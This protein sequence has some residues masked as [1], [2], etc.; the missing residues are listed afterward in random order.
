MKFGRRTQCNV[1]TQ[2]WYF[3]NAMQ[4]SQTSKNPVVR[5]R[6]SIIANYYLNG[7]YYKKKLMVNII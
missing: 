5:T 4:K 1:N 3:V 6:Q 2:L 7:Q